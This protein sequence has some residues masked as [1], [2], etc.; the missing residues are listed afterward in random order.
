[1]SYGYDDASRRTSITYP[2]G[3]NQATY[4]YDNANR[5]SSVT[6]WNSHATAYAYDDAGRMTTATLPSGTGIVSSYSYDNADR[7]TGISHVKN[8]STTVASLSYTLDDVGNRT[9]RVDQAGTHSYSYDDLYRLTSV[10]YPGPA[11]TSYAFDAFGNR[12]S[13]TVGAA[14]T[15]YS[16]DDADRI[17]AVTPPSPASA[18]NYTWDDNGDLTARGSDS[19][20]WDYED[21]MVSATVSS[22]T[23]AFAYRGDGLR[24]SKTTG[25]NTTTF[26]WDVAGGLPVVLDDGNQYLYGAG[27]VSQKQSGNWYYYLSDGL[28][29]TMA[30]VDSSGNTQNTYTYDVYGTPTKS[31]SLPNEFDFAGQET[32]GSTGLQYLRARYYDPGTGTFASR[33]SLAGRRSWLGNTFAYA[34]SDP[35]GVSDPTGLCGTF[36]SLPD[37]VCGDVRVYG[38]TTVGDVGWETQEAVDQLASILGE[39]KNQIWQCTVWGVQ[40]EIAG[41][42][43][44]GGAGAILGA[45]TGCAAGVASTYAP[46]NWQ[47]QCL[48]W[49]AAGLIGS[50]GGVA[51]GAVGCLAGAA[52]NLANDDPV[53]QCIGWAFLALA[54][55]HRTNLISG[56]VA[57]IAAT[58]NTGGGGGAAGGGAGPS[59]GGGGGAGSW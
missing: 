26:T 32:D 41:A 30:I 47:S 48:I 24:N 20:S 4:A 37:W 11:T 28:G 33:D 49:A 10:T 54:S 45:Y 14:T 13:M 17:T 7:L 8:G 53:S 39:Y 18:I 29:S 57:G 36:I 22:V 12:T 15:S 40:G 58:V 34:F 31:G 6:D 27:L 51:A 19:F 21:R 52:A 2:G 44:G 1:V 35:A 5:L 25:G 42:V 50:K 43:T 46:D 23:T 38:N 59:A 3:S 16:Y 55:P 56:C 9:Q